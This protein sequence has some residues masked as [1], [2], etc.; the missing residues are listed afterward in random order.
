MSKRVFTMTFSKLLASALILILVAMPPVYADD[1]D[2]SPPEAGAPSQVT[3]DA[4]DEAVDESPGDSM[5]DS[6]GDLDDAAPELQDENTD[7]AN[8]ATTDEAPEDEAADDQSSAT[9]P[10]TQPAEPVIVQQVDPA[11]KQLEDYYSKVYGAPLQQRSRLAKL[12]AVM[13]LSKIDAPELTDQLITTIGERDQIISQL[14]WE[15]VLARS[16][17][18]TP[19][20]RLRWAQAGIKSADGG[21]FR[22]TTIAPVLEA[23]AQYP[24]SSRDQ[25]IVQELFERL[26]KETDPSTSEGEAA[27]VAGGRALAAWSDP[28]LIRRLYATTMTRANLFDRAVILFSQIPGTPQDGNKNEWRNWNMKA[29][30]V[31]TPANQLKPFNGSS[32]FFPK[33]EKIVDPNDPKWI[34]DAELPE[35][36]ISALRT[37]FCLDAT[38]SGARLNEFVT[39]FIETL[40]S[41]ID[42]ASDKNQMGVVY[43]RHEID[44]KVMVPC[45]QNPGNRPD[46]FRVFVLPVTSNIPELVFAMREMVLPIHKGHDNGGAAYVGALQ[47]AQQMLG[48]NRRDTISVVAL[49]G[50][51]KGTVGKEEYIPKVTQQLVDNGTI[52][53]FLPRDN[54][55]ERALA[56]GIAVSKHSPIFYLSDIQFLQDNQDQT[57]LDIFEESAF[58]QL[59]ERIL[60][61]ALPQ[62]YADR[63]DKIVIA[64]TKVLR[65]KDH[66]QKARALL[67]NPPLPNDQ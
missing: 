8:P 3:D 58:G 27:L 35:L 39:G 41:C 23:A 44:P 14:A 67:E 13:S 66:A 56:E 62:G 61:S 24:L 54:R 10:A 4:P 34:K 9:E 32:L 52:V 45:C 1:T 50:D 31:A 6:A 30:L 48:P 7:A 55:A 40:A 57:A 29:K 51:A 15:A 20:Q 46:D 17:S 59:A 16:E 49:F 12:V 42:I 64:I 38:G 37:V 63:A 21:A 53:F 60:N 36:K 25:A 43:Y 47:S 65:A 2:E 11:I 5:D 19:E 33:P 18:L 28:R 22:G 26:C